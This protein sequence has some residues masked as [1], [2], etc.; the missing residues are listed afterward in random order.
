MYIYIK[1][2]PV[3]VD[4]YERAA[5]LGHVGALG[6]LGRLQS[7][8][9]GCQIDMVQALKK[10]RQAVDGSST[11]GVGDNSSNSNS[12]T[13]AATLGSLL[14]RR[15]F[16]SEDSQMGLRYLRQAA[17]V[18]SAEAE[19]ELGQ[20]ELSDGKLD[21]AL[22]RF[23]IAEK[24][25]HVK[26]ILTLAR[27]HETGM[28]VQ[29]SCDEAIRRYKR[30]CEIGMWLEDPFGPRQVSQTLKQLNLKSQLNLQVLY[31]VVVLFHVE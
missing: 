11:V 10:L 30:V 20:I 19:Y 24:K 1:N 13:A 12:G 6:E 26:S 27:H 25:G 2:L 9:H 28:G 16:T 31:T 17:A 3:A 5:G 4:F 29:R 22:R 15:I 8:G 18:G 21:D 7:I 14:L 23:L